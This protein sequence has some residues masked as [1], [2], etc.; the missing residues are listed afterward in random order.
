MREHRARRARAGFVLAAA[1]LLLAPACGNESG[2]PGPSGSPQSPGRGEWLVGVTALGGSDAEKTETT[3]VHFNPAT[4]STD[5]VA[6]PP[7]T[8]ASTNPAMT[9]LLVSGNRR[10][11]VPDLEIPPAREKS[12]QLKVYSLEDGSPREL[13]LHALAD[14][15]MRPIAWAFDPREPATLRLVDAHYGVWSLDLSAGGHQ[16]KAQES[17]ELRSHG[18]V[19]T[20]TFDP[21]TAQPYVESL[22]GTT[23]Y[24]GDMQARLDAPIERA[25]GTLLPTDSRQ[26][27]ALPKNPCELAAG[28][29]ASSGETWLICADGTRLRAYV[30]EEGGST[31][32]PYGKQSPEVA[33]EVASMTVVL[34][35][36]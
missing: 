34:P 15:D 7:V 25:G 2:G 33:L 14:A 9:P 35:P 4:G 22:D 30:L 16:Q 36:K 28:F 8:A 17:G 18:T 11:A 13:D 26:L 21:N 31:W 6:L 10:W 24:P 3:Y 23:T 12:G 19:F 5:K 29:R 27:R 1:L 32:Q 20:N